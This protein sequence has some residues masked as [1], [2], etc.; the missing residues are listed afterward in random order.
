VCTGC[1]ASACP[2]CS[3][4]YPTK[5]CKTNGSCGCALLVPTLCQ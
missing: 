2:A 3:G 5:C 1:V 4:L